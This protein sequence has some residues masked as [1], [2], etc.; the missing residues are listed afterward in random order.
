[1]QPADGTTWPTFDELDDATPPGTSW[2]AFGAT[3]G[4]GTVNFITPR[5]VAAAAALVKRGVPIGLD[6][7]INRFDPFPS[8][9]RG[10][11]QHHVF[12]NNPLHRDD[13]LDS[14]YLQSTSQIDALRHIGHPETGF[15]LGLSPEQNDA[16]P[17]LLGIH[18]WG[19]S[20]IVG[21]GIL[22]DAARWAAELG[23][24]L[25]VEASVSLSVADLEAIAAWEGV[26]VKPGD[27]LILRTGWA[28]HYLSLDE[29]ARAEFN[30]RNASPGLAQK[31]EMLCWLWNNR[32]AMVAADNPGVESDP[33]V[34]SDFVL[35]D[36]P[37]PHRG[38]NHNGMLH[39]PLIAQ[40][41]MAV[42]EY[43]KL[44]ELSTDCATD[45][46]YEFLLTVKPL[47]LV[48]GAGSPPNAIAIK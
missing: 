34:D 44:D 35:P 31:R 14:F 36:Q 5:E 4:R 12:Q 1:M 13:Y 40:L 42:G 20:G 29:D 25:D 33:V 16:H 19:E 15:Y 43:W 46:V 22:L 9:L 24:P 17:E 41:G 30:R 11:A 26:S 18:N 48:G 37:P 38:F 6:Y 45:G 7:R 10:A 8:G 28:E 47:N 27:I 2:A 21:R 39:R 23:R 32:I 3:S